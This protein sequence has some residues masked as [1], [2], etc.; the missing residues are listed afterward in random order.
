MNSYQKNIAEESDIHLNTKNSQQNT[1]NNITC[2]SSDSMN[3]NTLE[4]ITIRRI[5]EEEQKLTMEIEK[6]RQRLSQLEQ[7]KMKLIIEEQERR[8][9]I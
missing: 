3:I 6:E 7:E 1:I 4:S 8:Q 9:K 5:D 2:I